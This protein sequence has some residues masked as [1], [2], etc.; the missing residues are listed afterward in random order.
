MPSKAGLAGAFKG[1][2]R[3]TVSGESSSASGQL[4]RRQRGQQRP[5]VRTS[6][7][8]SANDECENTSGAASAMLGS[9]LGST[10]TCVC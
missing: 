4:A 2:H 9:V 5:V 6:M 10:P 3:E 1:R 7:S 8:D